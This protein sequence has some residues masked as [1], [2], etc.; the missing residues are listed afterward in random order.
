M[1]LCALLFGAM[2]RLTTP[3]IVEDNDRLSDFHLVSNY[4]L[5]ERLPPIDNWLPHQRLNY[6][7]AFQHYSAALLG[8]LFGLGP[9]VAF[10]LAAVILGAL[11]LALAWE[12]LTILRVRFGLKLLSVAALAI[13]GTGIS[14]LFHLITSTFP[15]RLSPRRIRLPRR[16]LQ[17]PLRRMVRHISGVRCLALALWRNPTL[18]PI[19]NRDVRLSIRAW[20]LPRSFVRL[21]AAVLGAH[22]HRCAP[23]VIEGSPG[24]PGISAWPHAAADTVLEC[25]GVSSPGG[26]DRLLENLGSARLWPSG[27]ALSGERWAIGV[28][29]LLPYLAD[30]WLGSDLFAATTR[31]DE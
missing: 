11:V 25:L 9:G 29:V 6:Y 19:A 1:F 31:N 23:S 22:C 5:G 15:D 20:R 17:F 8:R 13:G 2:W 16:T 10:N 3:D 12:F 7:Y 26:I 4:L 28:L 21:P 30:S 14:P 27:I 24:T 18:V